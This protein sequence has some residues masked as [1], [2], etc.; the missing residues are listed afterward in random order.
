M[1][2]KGIIFLVAIALASIVSLSIWNY[3]SSQKKDILAT[4]NL[5]QSFVQ[6]Q[7]YSSVPAQ[8][9][10]KIF[11]D[12]KPQY[13]Q[14][15][16]RTDNT[17]VVDP[18][19]TSI[20]YVGV[21]YKGVFKSIDKGKTWRKISKGIPG[22]YKKDNQ[23]EICLFELGKIVIDPKNSQR[24]LLVP[25]GSPGTLKI[26]QTQNGGLYES[27]DGGENWHQLI[28]DWMNS[29]GSEQ[30]LVLDPNNSQTIYYGANN[31][32][33]S[34]QGA[35]KNKTYQKVGVLYKT[36][37]GGK[38]WQELPT[39]LLENLRA[40]YVAVNPS[41]YQEILLMT[42][43]FVRGDNEA[44]VLSKQ[45]GPIKSLDG[46]RTWK[47]YADKLPEGYKG[48]SEA[49]AS[50]HNFNHVFLIPHNVGGGG[51]QGF[52]SHDGLETISKSSN[53]PF[54]VEYDPHD[55]S[56]NHVVGVQGYHLSLIESFDAGKTW[57][58]VG[59]LP[60]VFTQ[61]N[62]VMTLRPTNIVWDP[63]DK[64]TVYLTAAEGLV[65]RT[66]NFGTS[67]EQVSGLAR[68]IDVD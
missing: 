26:P 12:C 3:F 61:Q 33:S 54:L 22:A 11:T 6:D 62:I 52:Y 45:L 50:L 36:T 2:Q 21:E 7:N 38:N 20:L 14:D 47:S 9:Q 37:D 57:V 17:F 64:N 35:E 60:S 40:G 30:S 53:S 56:G 51:T 13:S 65:F 16:Y 4:D 8:T 27:L 67:W 46:G 5:P 42:A 25:V 44:S 34:W 66:I 58:E 39:G 28:A 1:N 48:V 15:H 41:N 59:K 49:R 55:T 63:R 10:K 19:N 32:G 31:Q 68:L 43:A 24:L 18:Q 29:S 23:E